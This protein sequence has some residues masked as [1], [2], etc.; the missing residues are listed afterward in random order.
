MHAPRLNQAYTS[1]YRDGTFLS[2]FDG[3]AHQVQNYLPDSDRIAQK[4]WLLALGALGTAEGSAI[5]GDPD[6]FCVGLRSLESDDLTQEFAHLEWNGLKNQP[7][8]LDL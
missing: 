8:R 3:V 2:E 7:A 6:P 1:G 4:V 5:A